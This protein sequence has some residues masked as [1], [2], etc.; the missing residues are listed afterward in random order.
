MPCCSSHLLQRAMEYRAQ[1][2]TNTD[3][4]PNILIPKVSWENKMN[5]GYL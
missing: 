3:Y 2:R 5:G 4:I 1:T